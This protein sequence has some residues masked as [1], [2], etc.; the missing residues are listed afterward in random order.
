MDGKRIWFYIA[1]VFSACLGIG[2]TAPLEAG[3]LV[4]LDYWSPGAGKEAQAVEGGWQWGEGHFYLLG[5]GPDLNQLT[6]THSVRVSAW[7]SDD[8]GSATK[9]LGSIVGDLKDT[10]TNAFTDAVQRI[11]VMADSSTMSL[12][13][14]VDFH[15]DAGWLKDFDEFAEGLF[16]NVTGQE[17]SGIIGW[18]L[19]KSIKGLLK[20]A[21]VDIFGDIDWDQCLE[22]NFP[23]PEPAAPEMLFAMAAPPPN[24]ASAIPEPASLGLLSLGLVMM[25]GRR[26]RMDS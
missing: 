15:E 19:T 13:A 16:E 22:Q 14:D 9:H 24:M 5:D 11:N 21:G 23:T 8:N 10:P 3:F 6:F 4:E 7:V 25:F 26:R 12:F 1:I 2:L 20:L 18:A 17:G